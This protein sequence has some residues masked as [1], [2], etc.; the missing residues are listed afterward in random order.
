M[1]WSF[2]NQPTTRR[3]HDPLCLGE[4]SWHNC[5]C[6]IF[7]RVREDERERMRLSIYMNG[8][9]SGYDD[10]RKDAARILKRVLKGRKKSLRKL[11]IKAVKDPNA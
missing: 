9:S 11:A 10:G 7:E 4:I 3:G 8:W 1:K 6:D 2:K 5:D